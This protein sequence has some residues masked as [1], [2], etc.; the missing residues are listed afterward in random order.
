M[1]IQK[2]QNIF[3][4]NGKVKMFTNQIGNLA[5]SL[6][7]ISSVIKNGYL[8]EQDIYIN[9]VISRA[10]QQNILVKSKSPPLSTFVL[11]F[12]TV[13]VIQVVGFHFSESNLMLQLHLSVA[14]RSFS[15]SRIEP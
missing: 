11:K 9:S 2:I 8:A 7:Q 10:C 13:S 12:G 15:S 1:Q 3:F 14:T 5:A 4:L 6:Y